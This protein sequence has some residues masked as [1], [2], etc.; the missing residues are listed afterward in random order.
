LIKNGN[1]LKSK[2]HTIETNQGAISF[3]KEGRVSNSGG[4]NSIT[5][6]TTAISSTNMPPNQQKHRRQN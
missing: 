4:N 1:I 5:K 2:A 6:K 3:P